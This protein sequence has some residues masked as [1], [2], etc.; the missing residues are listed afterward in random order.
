MHFTLLPASVLAALR[1]A[2]VNAAPLQ[3]LEDFNARSEQRSLS[4][5]LQNAVSWLCDLP[6]VDRICQK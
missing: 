1:I 4:S 2:Y 6:R 5:S 3:N